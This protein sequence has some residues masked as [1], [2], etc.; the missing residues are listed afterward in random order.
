VREIGPHISA[1]HVFVVAMLALKG[2][3]RKWGD[4]KKKER[5]RKMEE[6]RQFVCSRYEGGLDGRFELAAWWK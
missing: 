4:Q 6:D 5:R 3:T 2:E 1:A